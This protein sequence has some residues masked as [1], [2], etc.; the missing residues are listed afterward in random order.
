L[1]ANRVSS[2]ITSP[3]SFTLET[4]K[5][6]FEKRM[7]WVQDNVNPIEKVEKT[8]ILMASTIHGVEPSALVENQAQSGR[9]IQSFPA[10]FTLSQADEE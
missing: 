1:N 10:L 9:L 5:A 6:F 2:H 8:M 4:L 3:F 7:S